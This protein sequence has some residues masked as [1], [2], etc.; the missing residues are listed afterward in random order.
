MKLRIV[1]FSLSCGLLL[2]AGLKTPGIQI[3]FANLKEEARVLVE[4][5]GHIAAAD[6]VLVLNRSK[7]TLVRINAKTNKP[8]DPVA[9]LKKP[10]S[11]I[12]TGFDSI[13][14]PSCEGQSLM[15]IETKT[16]KITATIATGVAD[17]H[18]GIAAT[19]DSIW[20]F[21][22]N[23][24]TLSSIDPEQNQVVGEM[25]LSPDCANLLSAESSLW[26]TC[27]SDNRL[28]RISPAKHVV[29]KRIEVSPGPGAIAFG[30]GSIWILSVKEGKIDRLDPKTNKIIKTIDLV[31]P[32]VAGE[33]AFSDGFLWVSQP[34]F[35]LTRIDTTA[36]KERV[37][38]QF[39]GEGGGMIA[40]QTGAI[41]ITTPGGVARF[42]PKRVIATLAE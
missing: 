35:P 39:R 6:S 42:D 14:V 30:D 5:P 16:G 10:C 40:T 25:R 37:A 4:S 13:W 38:Q 21:T 34:G 17:I 41:W 23:R 7:D 32:G 22:D 18:S 3:P 36:E 11:G 2:A 24:G 33:L 27:P 15:R 31:T 26:V 29:E 19:A 9:A 8:Q 1:S 20:L 28:V 12:A